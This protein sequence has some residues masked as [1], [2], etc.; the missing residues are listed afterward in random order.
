LFFLGEF[1]LCV[2]V[3]LQGIHYGIGSSYGMCGQLRVDEKW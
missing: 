2:C 3:Y 1:C